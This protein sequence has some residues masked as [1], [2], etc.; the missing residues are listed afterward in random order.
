MLKALACVLLLSAAPARAEEHV[1]ANDDGGLIVQYIA[2]YVEWDNA[3]DTVRIAGDCSS[4]CT[5]ALGLF[6]YNNICAVKGAK[7]GFHSGGYRGGYSKGATELLWFFY[8]G[9]TERVLKRHGWRG[10]SDHPQLLYIDAQ[11]IVRPCQG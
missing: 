7:F 6:N 1:I 9:K 11:E 5:I 8:A 3:G 2:K 10:P 4:A